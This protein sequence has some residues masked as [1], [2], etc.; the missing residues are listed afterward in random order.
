MKPQRTSQL[1][2]L[3]TDLLTYDVVLVPTPLPLLVEK[4]VQAPRHGRRQRLHV[5]VE[6]QLQRDDALMDRGDRAGSTPGQR[7]VR[8]FRLSVGPGGVVMISLTYSMGSVA[9]RRLATRA[10]EHRSQRRNAAASRRDFG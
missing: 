3:L 8:R 6:P 2:V 9:E 4:R 10:Q 5:C 7:R 1:A